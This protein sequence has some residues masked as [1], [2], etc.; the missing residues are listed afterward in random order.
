[1]FPSAERTSVDKRTL[2]QDDMNA[3]CDIYEP[4]DLDQSC[5]AVPLGGLLLNCETTLDGDPIACEQPAS[6]GCRS[7][8]GQPANEAWMSLLFG[9]AGLIVVRWRPR[10]RVAGS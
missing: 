8:T 5:D 10:R 1:M 4:G 2:E 7:S 6:G 9:L 3:V